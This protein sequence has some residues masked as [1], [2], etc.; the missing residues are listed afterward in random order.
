[1]TTTSSEGKSTWFDRLAAEHGVVYNGLQKGR[2]GSVFPLF[3]HKNFGTFAVLENE[4]LAEAIERKRIQF[5][6]SEGQEP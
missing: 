1:M 3:T 4:T 2:M 6:Q 5:Q